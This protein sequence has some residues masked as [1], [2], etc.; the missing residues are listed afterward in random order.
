MALVEGNTKLVSSTEVVDSTMVKDDMKQHVFVFSEQSGVQPWVPVASHCQPDTPLLIGMP[1]W[2]CTSKNTK[3][4]KT[5]NKKYIRRSWGKYKNQS[6][7]YT[8]RIIK[9]FTEANIL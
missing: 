7:E 2:L 1:P 8:K 9:V 6:M 3:Y 5:Q 4:K